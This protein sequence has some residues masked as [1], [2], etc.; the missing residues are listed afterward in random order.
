MKY[1]F[2][3]LGSIGRRHLDNLISL[4]EKNII[5]YRRKDL[6][7]DDVSIKIPIFTDI[8]KAIV[9]KP[10]VAFI[11][12]PSAFHMQLA[13]KLAK[14]GCHLFIEKPLSINLQG[15]EELLE[16]SRERKLA[17]FIGFMM[18][19][20]PAVRQI[21]EWISHDLIG[22]PISV[23]MSCGE[24]LPLWHPH[25]DYRKSYAGNAKLGG[26]PIFTLCHEIDILSWLFGQPISLFALSS[27]KSSLEITTEHAVEILMQFKDKLVAEIHLDYLQNPAERKW[28]IIGNEGKI[29]FDYYS[30]ILELHSYKNKRKIVTKKTIIYNDR[31]RRNDM[32]KLELKSFIDSIRMNKKTEISLQDGIDNLKIL[33]SIHKSIK[34]KRLVKI[35][36]IRL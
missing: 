19:Y 22:F 23:R 28:S 10:D 29:E 21:K 3:G 25:E 11:T 31:F 32:F 6:Q 18:R 20:H 27:R 35:E 15:S 1:L 16:I 8:N 14:S 30:N 7:I 17:I 13:L 26:G 9:Q 36:E 12:N 5:A 2:C 33:L 24:Y 4:G 34:E